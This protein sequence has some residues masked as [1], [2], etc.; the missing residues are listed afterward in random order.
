MNA[1]LGQKVSI[2]TNKPQTTRHKVLGIL[3]T[4]SYQVVFLDTPGLITPRY[5]L[6]EAM[7]ISA[8]S[9]MQDADL[10]LFMIDAASPGAVEEQRD[11]LSRLRGLGKP[12][13]LVLN[14]ID[15]VPKNNLLPLT[16]THAKRYPY[17]EI[18]PVSALRLDGTSALLE[19]VVREMP[20]HPAYFPADTLSDQNQRFFVSEI[21]REKIFLKTQEEVPYAATVDILEFKEREE[22]KWFVRAEVYVERDSQRVILI[23]KNGS[24]LKEIGRM[25]RQDIERFLDHPVYL[26]IHVKV[27]EKWRS[28]EEWVKRLGYRA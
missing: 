16:D 6:H 23:G 7:M 13:F 9:A 8:T 26:E 2:V 17:R 27:R 21:I 24:M 25:A 28:D 5:A 20:L 18:F 4:G 10:L 15:R 11:V 22:G 1:L 19:A 12:V 14:K 3:T